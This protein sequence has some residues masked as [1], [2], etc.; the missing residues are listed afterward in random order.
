MS[1]DKFTSAFFT[2]PFAF[3]PRY[4]GF[5]I[6]KMWLYFDKL[7]SPNRSKAMKTVKAV[8]LLIVLGLASNALAGKA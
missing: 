2:P 3:R 6:R 1:P 4:Y 7:I 5:E 8:L